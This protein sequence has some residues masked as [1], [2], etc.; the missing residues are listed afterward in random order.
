MT[1]RLKRKAYWVVVTANFERVNLR[2]SV[3]PSFTMPPYLWP[4]T[5][6]CGLCG[7]GHSVSLNHSLT[8]TPLDLS[9]QCLQIWK[10]LD[11]YNRKSFHYQRCHAHRENRE[12]IGTGCFMFLQR[13]VHYGGDPLRAAAVQKP[14]LVA[15]PG[16]FTWTCQSTLTGITRLSPTSSTWRHSNKYT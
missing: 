1:G 6:G 4:L 3:Y 9:P 12:R 16:S 2:Q 13:H 5:P 7:K 11:E 8:Q 10:G 14:S 15:R